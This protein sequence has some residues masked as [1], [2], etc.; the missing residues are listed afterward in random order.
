MIVADERGDDIG[1]D[2]YTHKYTRRRHKNIHNRKQVIHLYQRHS[3]I[4]T[5]MLLASSSSSYMLASCYLI[6]YNI[7]PIIPLLLSHLFF[8]L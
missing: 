8:P 5:L 1:G 3:V 4:D 2:M 7:Q 6:Y